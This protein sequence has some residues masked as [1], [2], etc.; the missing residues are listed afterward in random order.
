MH[1]NLISGV[2]ALA[3]VIAGGAAALAD[4]HMNLK[5]ETITVFGPWLGVDKEHIEAVLAP[6]EE[7]TGA[8]VEYAGSDSFEQ[9]IVIDSQA[10][11]AP[12]VAIFP[13]PGLAA[14]LASKGLLTPLGD[15]T[16]AWV[17]ENYAAGQSWVD[18]GTYADASGNPDYFGFFYK[19]DVK[20]LVWY[21]PD[22]FEGC[23][24]LCSQ[25]PWKTCSH[26]A[27]K[28]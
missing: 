26:S 10:G 14:D 7:K 21:S 19:V 13:Q 27:T 3:L 24:L 12:N 20:S 16:K 22:N 8:N 9:Q 17:Q 5:G 28:S 2:S 25:R 6:F 15:E 4:D 18:L 1:K 11:S 23:R